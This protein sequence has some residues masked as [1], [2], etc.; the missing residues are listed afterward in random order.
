M[1]YIAYLGW[2]YI[3]LPVHYFRNIG[4]LREPT[5]AAAAGRAMRCK[6]SGYGFGSS[7]DLSLLDF[8]FRPVNQLHSVRYGYLVSTD[9]EQSFES[10]E[11]NRTLWSTIVNSRWSKYLLF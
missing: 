10:P 6:P 5:D 1:Q 11:T 7:S 3:S 2:Y 4:A 9:P 8:R